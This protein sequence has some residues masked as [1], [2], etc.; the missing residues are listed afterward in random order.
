VNPLEETGRRRSIRVVCGRLRSEGSELCQL[1]GNKS[2]GVCLRVSFW[3]FMRLVN[4]HEAIGSYQ[5]IHINTDGIQGEIAV[6]LVLV[7]TVIPPQFSSSKFQQLASQFP[8]LSSTDLLPLQP[9]T[10]LPL[11]SQPHF[12]KIPLKPPTHLFPTW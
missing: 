6:Y 2:F 3:R 12:F 1:T 8:S 5:C 10:S 11:I 7:R 9:F 4:A